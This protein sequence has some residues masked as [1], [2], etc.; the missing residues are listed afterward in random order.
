MAYVT[1]LGKIQLAG[2]NGEHSHML[3][4]VSKPKSD[5]MNLTHEALGAAP[6]PPLL[7]SHTHALS[8][9]TMSPESPHTFCWTVV[10][11]SFHS[12]SN[13]YKAPSMCLLLHFCSD[14]IKM[15]MIDPFP[16]D[17]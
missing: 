4:N 13:L 15:D 12:F 17:T 14:M 2:M 3:Q 7:S 10:R 5:I 9:L 11:L 16:K 6:C 8:Q 1:C